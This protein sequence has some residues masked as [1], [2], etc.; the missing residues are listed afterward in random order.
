[1]GNSIFEMNGGSSHRLDENR[2]IGEKTEI[3][4]S[5]AALETV[6]PYEAPVRTGGK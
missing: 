3:S 2:D 1:M 6:Q 4:A 5:D